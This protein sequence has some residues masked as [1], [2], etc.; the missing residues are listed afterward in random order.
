M[1]W[2]VREGPFGRGKTLVRALGNK[3]AEVI[4]P[5]G[6]PL[7]PPERMSEL[8][9][10]RFTKFRSGRIMMR[11]RVMSPEEAKELATGQ[12]EWIQSQ[13][14]E[15]AARESAIRALPEHEGLWF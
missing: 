8:M 10:W 4:A 6:V 7:N 13:I 1:V 15:L 14:E 11:P 2:K 3:T 5:P 9:Q 12:A